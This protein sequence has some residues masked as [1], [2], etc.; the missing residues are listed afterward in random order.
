MGKN[1]CDDNA[2]ASSLNVLVFNFTN[3]HAMCHRSD[4]FLA[5]STKVDIL[6]P[7]LYLTIT[8][9]VTVIH[10]E[11]PIVQFPT[12]M[13]D[14]KWLNTSWLEVII[15]SNNERVIFRDSSEFTQQ[16]TFDGWWAS[17]NIS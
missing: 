14:T 6:E 9:F 1:A 11:F 12:A 2:T 13:S 3:M 5:S 7:A 16:L 15:S 10:V 17:M 8:H 4:F